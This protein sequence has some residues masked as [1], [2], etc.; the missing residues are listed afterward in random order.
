MAWPFHHIPSWNF[1]APPELQMPRTLVVWFPP[2]WKK[3]MQPS[4]WC[5]LF[6]FP[7]F[8]GGT[9]K[10]LAVATNEFF[11]FLM[12]KVNENSQTLDPTVQLSKVKAK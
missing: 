4:K 12:S 2:L 5:S 8:A 3:N 1:R 6:I 11:I 9:T 10:N 7:N